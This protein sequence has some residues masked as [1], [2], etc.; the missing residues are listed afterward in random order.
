MRKKLL[1]LISLLLILI[2]SV[3]AQSRFKTVNYLNSITGKYIVSGQHND[4]KDGTN[5]SYWTN[6]VNQLTGKYPA[7]YSGDFLFNGDGPARWAITYE[8]ERQWNAGAIVN[9][10][11][12]T[13]PPI[14]G[15][16]CNWDG[17]LLSSLNAS[18][19]SE[20]LT[21]GS[22]LN[23]IWKS[24][25]DQVSVYLQYLEDKGV[26]VLW[27]PLHEQNQTAFWWN[28]GGAGNTK[29]LWKM[30]HD[31][32]TNTKGL[33]NLVWVWDVQDMSTNFGDYNP[34]AAYYDIAALDIYGDGHTNTSYY[35][36]L[37]GQASGKPVATGETFKLPTQSEFNAQPNMSFFMVWAYGL[38]KDYNN[39]PQ[40]TNSVAEIQA[41]YA[42]PRVI[43]RDEMPGWNNVNAPTNLATRKLVTVSSTEAGANASTNAVDGS[44]T[45][46]W[47]S[48]YTDAQWL[49]VDLGAN[50][51]INRVKISWEAA[52]GKNYNINVS[53]DGVTWTTLKSVIGNTNLSNDH[54]GLS[55]T[56]RYVSVNGSLRGT[57]YGY[58][59]YELE[60]YGTTA[61]V[62]Q[63]PAVSLTSPAN[64]SNF[65]SPATL[66]ISATAADSDGSVS[67][68]DFYNGSTLLASDNTSPYSYTWTSV[69]AG[70]YTIT[71]KATDNSGAGTT[72]AAVTV[73]V[74]NSVTTSS[75]KVIGYVPTWSGNL[76]DV[77][78]AK[79]THINYAFLIPN[80]DGGYQGVSDPNRLNELV[81]RSHAAGVK[82]IISVGGGG[83]GDAFKSIVANAA[84]RTA[85]VNNMLN[86]VNQYNLDGVDIDWEYPSDGVEANNF[87]LM[88]K[89]LYSKMHS[90]GKLCT[91]AVIAYN[92]TS[93]LNEIF[94]AIDF[95]NIMAYDENSY[96]HSTFA[97]SVQSVNYWLGRGLPANKAVLGVPFYGRDRCCDYKTAAYKDILAMGGSPNADTYNNQIGYNG[98][99]T[100]K[101]KTAYAMQA[102]GGIM[103]WELSQDAIGVNSLLSAINQVV[104]TNT[105]PVPMNLAMGKPVTA[106]SSEAGANVATNAVD[107]SYSTRWSS[108]YSDAQWLTVDLGA[109][110][111]INRVKLTW[112]AAYGKDYRITGSV[113]G[114]T[115]FT[116]KTITGNTSL[117]NDLTG[118]TG[119]CR[120]ISMNGTARGTVYG[121]SIYELEVYG[122]AVTN[123]NQAPSVSLTSPSTNASYNAPASVTIS[124][125]ATDSDGSVT[126]VDFYSGSTLLFNDYTAP[127]TYTW[128]NVAAGTYAIT[129]R[130]TDNSG[131]GTTSSTLTIAVVNVVTNTCAST[132]L[133]VENGGYTAGSKVKNNNRQYECKPY[134]YSGWCNGAAWAYGPG[135]GAYWTDAWL[136]KGSCTAKTENDTESESIVGLSIS[137]NPASNYLKVNTTK[138]VKLRILDAQGRECMNIL[139]VEPNSEISLERLSAGLY[140]VQIDTG[141]EFITK[142]LIKQ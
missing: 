130:A 87:V 105:N 106:S 63:P 126:K 16:V 132:A 8:A 50:Y 90:N 127:F 79:L 103:I 38:E 91:I 115:W 138:P 60:V 37:L 23:T 66:S 112:E 134:P 71:A 74:N 94:N 89:E 36:A 83:G 119:N 141:T 44:Y 61:T 9:M 72:S 49:T 93:I 15:D 107:G 47:S 133:Y 137:P 96:D 109:T 135:V 131:A 114:T 54:T 68:V 19:W 81:S 4:Q 31:Y 46:R 129:A 14:Q 2:V 40:Q 43:T 136:D 35:N 57:A 64:N 97:L 123:V 98:I 102:C 45:T 17:G 139:E 5:E 7:L 86:F 25:I 95:L 75:F 120:Y 26:E 12:H 121:Y 10:M 101:Q 84:Y 65:T 56:C 58:S 27:R 122:S 73:V 21:N 99:P 88:M 77:Q 110:Y 18:Q 104:V 11:W 108:L 69:A 62:N 117:T 51:D 82:V 80:Y 100:M 125:N 92:G 34:G 128:T 1:L 24:R 78:Y 30:T 22:N 3:Q 20:L 124:A 111:A 70:T 6:R 59:I 85:F 52:Y 41:C 142:T 32:M 76:A 55:G 140:Y 113:D 28:S 67:K 39:P 116:L 42:N 29:A 118:L 33:S 48:L 13:C 53:T